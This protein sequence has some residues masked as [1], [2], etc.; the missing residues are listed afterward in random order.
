MGVSTDGQLCYGVLL[1]EGCEL[2]WDA[3]DDYE[4]WWRSVNGYERVVPLEELYADDGQRA[5]TFTQ[6]RLEQQWA[7][8]K[9]W[10]A[11][12][13]MPFEVVNVCSEDYPIWML[14]VRGTV[15]RAWRGDPKEIEP[16]MLELDSEAWEAFDEAMRKHLPD[17]SL[18][19][20]GWYLSSYWG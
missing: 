8:Q 13:P 1:E 2:P 4:L 12:N 11:A 16:A 18:E 20:A 17:V 19:R 6:E 10:G 14:A 5:S 9:E 15:H 3:M 7:H